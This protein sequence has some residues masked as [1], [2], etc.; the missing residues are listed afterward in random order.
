MKSLMSRNGTINMKCSDEESFK[1]SVTR[2]LNPITKSSERITKT[3]KEQ[4]KNYNWGGV[5]FLT[6][7]SEG[8]TEILK[9]QPKNYYNWLE[10]D[11]ST[12][13][14]QIE[15]FERDNNL[16]VNVF[17]FDESRNCVTSLKL[18]KGVHEGR[19]L[20]MF[21][22]NRYTVVKSMSRLFCKQATSG[23]KAKRFYCNNCLQPFTS[24]E[25]LNDHVNSFCLP[26]K[27][28]ARDVCITYR[29]DIRVLKVRHT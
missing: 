7:S 26:F 2:A 6:K 13:L 9:E 12:P 20:L 1:W 16:L 23:R 4:S 11:F 17:G 22:N 21:T 15:T 28:D 25:K 27:M 24:D 8:I 10:V 29:G 3:L 19:V 18:S 14:K 5:D